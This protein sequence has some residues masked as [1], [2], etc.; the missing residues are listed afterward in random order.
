[1]RTA[2]R[3]TSPVCSTIQESVEEALEIRAEGEPATI[4]ARSICAARH[5]TDY[6][7]WQFSRDSPGHRCE[8]SGVS[9]AGAVRQ[10]LTLLELRGA[11]RYDEGSGSGMAAL[12]ET[13]R[14]LVEPERRLLKNRISSLHRRRK[15]YR[16]R[17]VTVALVLWTGGSALTLLA[18]RATSD[19]PTVLCL[20]WNCRANCG[21]G[22][23][24][25]TL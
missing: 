3:S 10:S 19:W 21:L 6:F 11:C 1:V 22:A 13:V 14:P 24:R 2:D 5:H 7:V 20:G 18:S 25:G 12:E 16:R 4:I 9:A 8:A 15:R 17:M 23:A